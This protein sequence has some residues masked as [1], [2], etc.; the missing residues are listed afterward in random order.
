MSFQPNLYPYMPVCWQTPFTVYPPQVRLSEQDRKIQT[1]ANH[2]FPNLDVPA[3]NLK[4][5]LSGFEIIK[6]LGKG[7]SAV[8][9]KVKLSEQEMALKIAVS[10]SL[11]G[12][13]ELESINHERLYETCPEF[14]L[15]PNQLFNIAIRNQFGAVYTRSVLPMKVGGQTLFDVFLSKDT[16]RVVPFFEII[17][18]TSQYLDFCQKLEDNGLAKADIHPRNILCEGHPEGLKYKFIDHVEVGEI[19]QDAPGPYMVTRNFR[20]PSVYLGKHTRS[21]YMFPLGCILYQL[22][23]GRYLFTTEL[24]EEPKSSRMLR[25]LNKTF[26]F[27]ETPPKEF[28]GL[29]FGQF[30]ELQ[31]D[32]PSHKCTPFKP[33]FDSFIDYQGNARG[34]ALGKIQEAMNHS[35]NKHTLLYLPEDKEARRQ[36][37]FDLLELIVLLT[38]YTNPPSLSDI[39]NHKVLKNYNWENPLIESA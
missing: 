29:L 39:R 33:I 30:P 14:I 19:N 24:K 2:L 22:I 21:N 28:L 27:C 23:T 32:N 11:N 6:F 17:S 18:F 7:G 10:S 1:I 4:D 31:S 5:A 8:V 12:L 34:D 13:L 25:H 38:N 3:Q 15:K 9:I 16:P 36:L 35:I 20:A 37:S 26:L